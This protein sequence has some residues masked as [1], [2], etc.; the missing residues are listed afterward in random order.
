MLALLVAALCHD[1]SHPGTN[2]TFQ[3]RTAS[4]VALTYNDRSVLENMHASVATKLLKK[5]RNDITANLSSSDRSEMRVLMIEGI[6]A[7]DMT[8]HFEM[9]A[10]LD[11]LF[12]K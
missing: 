2:N 9:V 10:Q 7:T 5:P 1:V 6:L 11:Q 12:D 8:H 4:E 3:V